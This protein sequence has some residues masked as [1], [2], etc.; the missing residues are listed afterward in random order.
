MRVITGTARGRK[1]LAPAGKAVRP[2]SAMVK[3]AI[4]SMVQFEVEGARVLDLFAGSGQMGIEALSRGA[5]ECVFVDST[6]ESLGALRAN[7]SSSGPWKNAKV[8]PSG[9]VEFLRGYSGA[10]FDIVF[11]DPPYDSAPLAEKCIR[12]LAGHMSSTGVV[13]CEVQDGEKLPQEFAPLV[14]RKAY[15]YGKTSVLHY[16][17]PGEGEE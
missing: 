14:L 12:L 7:L 4:F 15:K 16:R 10:A 9:A 13:I 6:R 11:M 3:E 2:T 17:V 1:L 8:V 5:R